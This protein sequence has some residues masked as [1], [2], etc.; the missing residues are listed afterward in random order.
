[1]AVCEQWQQ[2]AQA[3]YRDRWHRVPAAIDALARAVQAAQ[4]GDTLIL[5]D[6][7]HELSSTVNVDF[8]LRFRCALA[9]AASHSPRAKASP[10]ACRQPPAQPLLAAVR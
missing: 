3:N 9:R 7:V 6:G 5:D 8:P 4:P 1:M 2:A 10:P